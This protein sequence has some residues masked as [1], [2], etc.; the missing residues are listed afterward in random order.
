MHAKCTK[1]LIKIMA[2]C[3]KKQIDVTNKINK[4]PVYAKY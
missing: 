2:K 1:E 3:S 4:M